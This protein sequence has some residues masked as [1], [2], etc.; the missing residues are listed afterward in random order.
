MGAK[1]GSLC[2]SVL[3]FGC[4]LLQP[5]VGAGWNAVHCTYI[6]SVNQEL[7]VDIYVYHYTRNGVDRAPT[8]VRV[9][10]VRG[11]VKPTPTV[12]DRVPKTAREVH[13]L[14]ARISSL[15]APRQSNIK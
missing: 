6:I 15:K 3:R 11:A 7:A 5:A 4:D 1:Y 14:P 12:V 10:Q 9:A 13:Y 2:S 8:S